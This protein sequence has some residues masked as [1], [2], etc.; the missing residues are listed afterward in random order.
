[1]HLEPNLE[2]EMSLKFVVDEV[3]LG[4][5]VLDSLLHLLPGLHVGPVTVRL[6]TD[7]LPESS[8]D[9]RFSG[10]QEQS[11]N[12]NG[13]NQFYL[14]VVTISGC[15]FSMSGMTASCSSS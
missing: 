5:D 2:S 9:S 15:F 11:S 14:I 13:L 1:M 7:V 3:S 12:F 8:G 6:G 4:L 10:V